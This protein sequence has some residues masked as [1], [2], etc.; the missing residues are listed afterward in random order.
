MNRLFPDLNAFSNSLRKNSAILVLSVVLISATLAYQTPS[1]YAA[2]EFNSDLQDL[3]IPEIKMPRTSGV[4]GTE[5]KIIVSNL[6][7][8]PENTDPRMEFFMTLPFFEFSGNVPSKCGGEYCIALYT[9]DEIRN[10]D[11]ASKELTFT[12]FSEHN[13][14]PIILQDNLVS[15]CDVKINDKVVKSFGYL[16]NGKNVP[17]GEYEINFGWGIQMSDKY[18]W[19]KTI[20]FTVTEPSIP[21]ESNY[22]LSSTPY[23][24]VGDIDLLFLQYENG[25]ISATQFAEQLQKFGW[26]SDSIRKAFATINQGQWQDANSIGTHSASKLVNGL[27]LLTKPKLQFVS[28]QNEP[29]NQGEKENVGYDEDKTT[30]TQKLGLS[31]EKSSSLTSSDFPQD[32]VY[33]IVIA[34]IA[35]VSILVIAL[36]KNGII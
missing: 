12:L 5:V 18:D 19:S 33:G 11:L 2:F 22:V 3:M 26:N 9:F 34:G 28:E 25:L 20:T 16:C 21:T 6:M 10:G 4:S 8:L 13:P 1:S 17:T 35:L 30:S 31:Q 7:P 36:V 29:L 15:V 27:E 23:T 24:S 32:L 14:Q